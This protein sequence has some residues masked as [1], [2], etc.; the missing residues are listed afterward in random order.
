MANERPVENRPLSLNRAE[1]P[2]RTPIHGK[3]DI[4]G[5]KGLEA[6]WHYCWVNDDED[7]NLDRYSEGGFDF[8]THNVVVGDKKVDAASQIGGKVSKA[9][10]NGLTAYLMRCPQEVYE[11]EMGLLNTEV[12]ER[13]RG[14]KDSLNSKHDGQYGSVDIGSNKPLA[15]KKGFSSRPQ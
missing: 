2:H 6:G 12:D 7:G 10:G 15:Q 1:R 5:V 13:E 11:E 14:M 4:L 8:V 3:K 9:V